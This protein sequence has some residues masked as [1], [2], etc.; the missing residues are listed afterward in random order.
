[1]YS[2]TLPP[3]RFRRKAA[4][5]IKV[6]DLVDVTYQEGFIP[7]NFS[8]VEKIIHHRDGM[9]SI[10]VAKREHWGGVEQQALCPHDQSAT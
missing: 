3:G 5:N 9:I 7:A 10:I 1:M 4:K 2:T 6:G 8:P